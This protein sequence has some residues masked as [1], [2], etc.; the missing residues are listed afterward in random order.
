MR[1]ASLYKGTEDWIYGILGDGD[2]ITRSSLKIAGLVKIYLSVD[3]ELVQV[4]NLYKGVSTY[5]MMTLV[6]RLRNHGQ[7]INQKKDMHCF[8]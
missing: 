8:F 7:S 6:Q 1:R 5:S 4:A 2:V 3:L